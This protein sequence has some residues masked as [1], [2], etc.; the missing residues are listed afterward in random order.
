V[1]FGVERLVY[2]NSRQAVKEIFDKQSAATSCKGRLE[3][4][5]EIVHGLRLA[6]MPY[7][8]KWRTLRAAVHKLLTSKMVATFE[9]SMDF[10]GNQLLF[11]LLNHNDGY[12]RF[13]K[14]VQRYTFSSS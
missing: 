3:N 1:R 10:E 12:E 2:V 7:G 9:P 8:P 13:F 4:A 6:L 14:H 5:N 11:D